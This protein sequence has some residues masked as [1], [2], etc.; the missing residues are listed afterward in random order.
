MQTKKHINIKN[1]FKSTIATSLA[2]AL[3]VNMA[4]GAQPSI[5]GDEGN[6]DS[7]VGFTWNDDSSSGM[8]SPV[9]SNTQTPISKLI[10]QFGSSTSGS[11]D[12]NKYT[13]TIAGNSLMIS[14][15]GSG[16][17]MND[18]AGYFIVNF[19]QNKGK[20]LVL[21]LS[22]VSNTNFAL[23]GHFALSGMNDLSN[24]TN[25]TFGG[26]GVSRTV[27]LDSAG[28]VDL[29]LQSGA[30]IEGDLLLNDG[31]NTIHVQGDSKTSRFKTIQ[32]QN[33]GR[34][35]TK[36]LFDTP[37]GTNQHKLNDTLTLKNG[38]LIYGFADTVT[39]GTDFVVD[40]N[41]I[42]FEGGWL[43]FEGAR[44]ILIGDIGT[45]TLTAKQGGIKVI[46]DPRYAQANLKNP[47]LKGNLTLGNGSSGSNSGIRLSLKNATSGINPFTDPN[48]SGL[49]GLPTYHVDGIITLNNAGISAFWD[50]R[51]GFTGKIKAKQIVITGGLFEQNDA[52]FEFGTFSTGS[53]ISEIDLKN[54]TGHLVFEDK[55]DIA[56]GIK[57]RDGGNTKSQ[58][59]FKNNAHIGKVGQGDEGY[60]ILAK[61][62]GMTP[63]LEVFFQGKNNSVDGISAQPGTSAQT[64]PDKKIHVVFDSKSETNTIK[65]EIKAHKYSSGMGTVNID[66]NGKSHTI[67]GVINASGGVN[68][69]TFR[70]NA[71]IT[72]DIQVSD[73]GQNN[74]I[75]AGNGNSL[76]LKGKANG[77]NHTIT[78]L[79]STGTNN[80]L[81]LDSSNGSQ[82]GGG[83]KHDSSKSS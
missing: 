58:I 2:L 55:M 34:V 23:E 68:N 33:A 77:A 9:L 10:F 30:K 52:W 41:K 48:A 14:G 8:F 59:L 83:N 32:S 50:D 18:G 24:T 15:N 79:K 29:T 47:I 22:G 39:S 56:K 45:G 76:T 61:D 26:K 70:G 43:G 63:T 4:S 37:N 64:P 53:E 60:A 62:G 49:D 20:N 66:F 67:S 12:Q 42:T 51:Y 21:D 82:G 54:S 3:S 31:N 40:T 19:D 6:I 7:K 11:G 71:E 80:K 44:Q 13:S 38:T 73:N 17:K 36:I 46:V 69:L 72:N 65:G 25:I 35:T 5:A 81:I 78:L 74:F 57:I 28:K 75:L 1:T 27:T 16:I